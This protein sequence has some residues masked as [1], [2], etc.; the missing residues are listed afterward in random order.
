M[1]PR[2][3]LA[4]VSLA[5]IAFALAALVAVVVPTP[6]HGQPAAPAASAPTDP[7]TYGRDCGEA[8]VGRLVGR[9]EPVARS[10]SDAAGL[11]VAEDGFWTHC[12]AP[13][14]PP[15][16]P[17]DCYPARPDA[18]RT[19]SSGG[20]SCTSQVPPTDRVIQHGRSAAWLQSS[21]ATS[22]VLVERCDDGV[23]SV[24]GATCTSAST[25]GPRVEATRA[26]RVYVYAG[27][28]SLPLGA[29][30]MLRAADG[31]TWPATC[32]GGS[33]DV[34]SVL[35]RARPAQPERPAPVVGC[36]PGVW[37][38]AGRY[39]RHDGPVVQ[40]GQTIVAQGLMG[41]PPATFLCADGRF[42]APPKP[43][44]PA[45]SGSGAEEWQRGFEQQ[46]RDS[47]R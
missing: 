36:R 1:T 28:G 17:S 38:A 29:S 27:A 39:Y 5:A 32:R 22:G 14:A 46:Q 16:A 10:A 44:A 19:W 7:I 12:D 9:A 8:G 13:A 26:G 42:V 41:A 21:G 33:W 3:A 18:A 40:P 31:S 11:R 45:A 43:A 4:A 20:L 47:R 30:I 2:K 6:A 24:I 37:T 23:R 34:P 15:P 35:P 25:C